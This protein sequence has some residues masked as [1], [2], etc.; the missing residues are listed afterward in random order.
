VRVIPDQIE[1]DVGKEVVLLCRLL[2]ALSRPYLNWRNL[3][4]NRTVLALKVSF[5]V[6]LSSP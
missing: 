3:K 1:D 4:I 5:Y 2:M 6:F